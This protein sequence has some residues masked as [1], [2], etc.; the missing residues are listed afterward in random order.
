[1]EA[2]YHQEQKMPSNSTAQ[3]RELV[4]NWHITEACNFACRYCYAKWQADDMG[5]ELIHD[6]Q[7]TWN[8]LSGIYDYFRPEN[9]NNP[10][11]KEMAW[12]SLRLNLAGGE[13]LLYQKRT[14]EVIKAARQLGF[15][16]SIITNGSRMDRALA[17]EM[18]PHLSVLGVSLDSP[19]EQTNAAIGRID[20]R[21]EQLSIAELSSAIDLAKSVNSALKVKLNTVVNA[22]NWRQDISNLVA[23]LGPVKWKV[24]RMLPSVTDELAVTEQE[25]EYFVRRHQLHM[26]IMCVEDN[27]DMAESY[28]MIDPHGRFFQ[29]ALGRKGYVYSPPILESG[30]A[31]AYSHTGISVDKFVSRYSQKSGEAQV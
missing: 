30:V 20:R 31:S 18:A 15:T 28:L 5:R 27:A 29:N 16:V 11:R 14:I 9:L 13:P 4:V 21:S 1:L 23:S 6:R 3:N 25:F 26:Q 2:R 22:V 7:G 12:D 19:N 24:L 8:M 10:L 17:G